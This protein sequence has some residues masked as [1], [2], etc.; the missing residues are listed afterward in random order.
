M[1]L[2]AVWRDDSFSSGMDAGISGG[3][4]G[5]IA[6]SALAAEPI[7]ATS[8]LIQTMLCKFGFAVARL[9]RTSTIM[10]TM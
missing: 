10:H 2:F 4:A 5:S 6:L 9:Q 7:A 3:G 8:P 1:S